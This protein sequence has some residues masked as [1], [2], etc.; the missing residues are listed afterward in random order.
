MVRIGLSND[1][2]DGVHMQLC[3][4]DK[5]DAR[6]FLISIVKERTST[7]T[8]SSTSRIYAL[9]GLRPS[10]PPTSIQ[11][12][13]IYHQNSIYN[14]INRVNCSPCIGLSHLMLFSLLCSL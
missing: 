2:K 12:T 13:T 11:P 7:S 5:S 14:L 4:H 8:G 6:K 9:P 1:S 3:I 10:M